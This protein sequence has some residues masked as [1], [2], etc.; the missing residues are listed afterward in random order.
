M[1]PARRRIFLVN[2]PFQFR[3][4]F[5]VCS[6]L[7]ALSFIYPWIIHNLFDYF[8]RYVSMDPMGPELAGL[9]Q[10][11]QE[12]VLLLVAT[13]AGFLALTFL[14]SLFLA[15]RVA[16]PLHKL[17]LFFAKVR[18]GDMT[19]DLFFRQKDHFKDVAADYN[20]MMAGL[21]QR[22]DASAARVRQAAQKSSPEVRAE[23]EAALQL[24]PLTSSQKLP[25]GHSK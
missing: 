21:R 23:L 1:P 3:L 6:W 14:V 7:V 9:F 16:G 5:Y 20:D 25:Q 22:I 18:A 17:K 4:A 19:E 24:L 10:T 13:Q 2:K 8:V 12:I 15:H 11:R